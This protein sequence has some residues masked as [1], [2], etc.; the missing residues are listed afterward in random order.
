[1]NSS[2][3]S[4]DDS[5]HGLL[6]VWLKEAMMVASSSNDTRGA[7]GSVRV[8]SEIKVEEIFCH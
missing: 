4:C 1:M 8:A 7:G 5:G 3:K 6:E 2:V